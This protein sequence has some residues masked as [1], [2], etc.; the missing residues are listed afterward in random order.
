MR[1]RN[2]A[3][4]AALAAALAAPAFAGGSS[5]EAT[6]TLRDAVTAYSKYSYVGQVQNIDYGQNRANAVLFRVEHLAPNWTRRWYLAP[7]SL[8]GDSIISHGDVMYDVDAHSNKL[9]I[10]HDDALDDQVALDDNF[11]LL[12]HNYRAVAGPEDNIAGR[13]ADVVMLVNRYTGERVLRIAVDAQTHLVLQKERYASSGAVTYQMRFEQI[14]Y[15]GSIP[16]DMF[17]LPA[18]YTRLAGPSHGLP[19]N[20]FKSVVRVAG[21]EARSPKYLPEG[22]VPITGDVS[23][24]HGVR[25]LHLMYSDG[26]R[27]ISLFENARG[28]AVDMSRYAVHAS[29]VRSEDAQY[30]QEGSTTLLAWASGK[31]H[32]ALVGELSQEELL[33]IAGSV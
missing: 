20:D 7:E 27:T 4:A 26:L 33:R 9:I 19:S 13:R 10:T 8:Y 11:G 6:Q 23:D 16:Q 28:A 29:K 5:D 31:L 21:F 1:F 15:T 25:S 24:I 18:G 30:V 14:R 2:A 22:F 3:A 12:L 17:A 32:F